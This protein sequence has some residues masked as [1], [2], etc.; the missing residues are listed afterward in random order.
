MSCDSAAA[1][2]DDL[3]RF[4]GPSG[5]VL[6]PDGGPKRRDG[7]R[8]GGRSV[9]EQEKDWKEGLGILHDVCIIYIWSKS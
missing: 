2:G 1:V 4:W 3:D 9:L 7:V 6:G 8:P 5:S